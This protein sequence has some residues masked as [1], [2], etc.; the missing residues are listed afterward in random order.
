MVL[1]AEI[2]SLY[3]TGLEKSLQDI[4]KSNDYARYNGKMHLKKSIA[5]LL[6]QEDSHVTHYFLYD[7]KR[8]VITLL[9]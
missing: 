7:H 3:S 1:R 8:L 4:K 5:S 6:W 9:E 2:M